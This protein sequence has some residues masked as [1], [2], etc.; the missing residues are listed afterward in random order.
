[1]GSRNS[2]VR[3]ST[4]SSVRDHE[5]HSL[6][7]PLFKHF[8]QLPLTAIKGVITVVPSDDHSKSSSQNEQEANVL[9]GLDLCESHA[10]TKSLHSKHSARSA[11]QDRFLSTSSRDLR[12]SMRHDSASP[13]TPRKLTNSSI[14]D[15]VA[16]DALSLSGIS[17]TGMLLTSNSEPHSGKPSASAAS[18]T[19]TIFQAND[20]RSRDHWLSL[21]KFSLEQLSDFDDEEWCGGSEHGFFR[22]IPYNRLPSS[23]FGRNLVS[24]FKKLVHPSDVFKKMNH[25]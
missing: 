16:T 20:Q 7:R 13:R 8:K 1:M 17:G 25:T 22:D 4:R 21:L 14:S 12:V 9:W 24:K 5:T 11:L 23:S 15:A 2:G 19:I 10:E 3:A 18:Q 6:S